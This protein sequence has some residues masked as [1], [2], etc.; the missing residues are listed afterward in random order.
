[1]TA[2]ACDLGVVSC[3]CCKEPTELIDNVAGAGC[4]PRCAPLLERALA[5]G[6][7]VRLS[8]CQRVDA[9]APMTCGRVY[10]VVYVE[11]RLDSIVDA[12]HGACPACLPAQLAYV[13]SVRITPRGERPRA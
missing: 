10:G 12:S 6:G 4:C 8:I 3:A 11:R 2:V 7:C 5:E 13:D 9:E 1:M